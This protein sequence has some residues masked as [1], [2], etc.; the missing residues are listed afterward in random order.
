MKSSRSLSTL[1]TAIIA[2]SHVV[3]AIQVD[4]TSTGMSC[5]SISR[6]TFIDWISRLYQIRSQYDCVRYD[7]LLQWKPNGR[8]TRKPT[9][10]ILLVGGWSNVRSND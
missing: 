2:G 8:Y 5:A 10:T 1:T 6:I 7:A 3:N 4:L 9:T